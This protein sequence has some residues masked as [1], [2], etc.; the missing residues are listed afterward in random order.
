[1]L[2]L[3]L[4][5]KPDPAE[6]RWFTEALLKLDQEFPVTNNAEE[7]RLMAGVVMATTFAGRSRPA[8]AFALGL[9]V[10][11]MAGRT[12]DPV[13]PE[14]L[15][16]AEKYLRAEA[17][18][19]RPAEFGGGRR[20]EPGATESAHAAAVSAEVNQLPAG[21]HDQAVNTLS[22]EPPYLASEVRRLAEETGM[23]WWILTEY[24]ASLDCP[25][26]DLTATEYAL[27]AAAEAA[28]RTQIV[29]PPLSADALVTRALRPCKSAPDKT[30]TLA[31][32]LAATNP[33]WRDV[34]LTQIGHIDFPYLVP[35]T[36]AL[37]KNQ[38]IDDA[39]QAAQ[40]AAKLCP[41]I[42][43]EHPLSP[44][45]IAHLFYCELMFFKALSAL[46]A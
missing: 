6:I 44:S 5:A 43:A 41:G 4:F 12:I 34:R 2:R 8:N 11:Q 27:A 14:I 19:L 24:S 31:D 3:F 33:T 29:P 35:V 17:E 25:T 7:L 46:E 38:E 30:L 23:L 26:S 18:R 45:E 37:T 39:A 40:V 32:F 13:Q 21:G 20:L 42:V 1:L 10:T 36:T 22:G 9:R 15:A 28:D 16:E